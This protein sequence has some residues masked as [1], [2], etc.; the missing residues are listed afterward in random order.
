MQLWS[1]RENNVDVKETEN[2]KHDGKYVNTG[3][4][5]LMINA[6]IGIENEQ[7]LLFLLFFNFG[8]EVGQLMLVPIFGSII[9]LAQKFDLYKQSATLTSLILGGMGFFWLID[10]VTGII[11]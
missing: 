11:G 3:Y 2:F 8:I 5:R 10:R 7:L 1:K 9:W 4:A 6:G